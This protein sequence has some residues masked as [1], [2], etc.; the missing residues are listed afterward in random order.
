MQRKGKYF[1]NL[2]KYFKSIG[3]D[4]D[5]RVLNA[6]EFGVLQDRK[7]VIIIGWRKDLDFFHILFL[8]SRKIIIV[9]KIYY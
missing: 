9:L 3:Y 6:S 2:K 1:N 5:Y 7:R 8:I 4:L